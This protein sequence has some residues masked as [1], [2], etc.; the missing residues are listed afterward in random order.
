[1]KSTI[2]VLDQPKSA[3]ARRARFYIVLEANRPTAGSARWSLQ[4]VE[5]V[6]IGR[7]DVRAG[8]RNRVDGA[9]RLTI[10]IP[11]PR[12]S[13]SHARVARVAGQWVLED[14]ESKNGT[15]V[16]GVAVTRAVLRTGDSVEMGGTLWQYAEEL[17]T[18][19]D[20]GDL[21][22]AT[23]DAAPRGFASVVAS[24]E[25]S[26]S[27]LRTVARTSAVPI[28]LTGE[29]GTG[30]ELAARAV[31]ELSERKGRF[32]AVNCGAIPDALVESELFGHRRGAFSGATEDRAGF[33][34]SADG[35]TLLL[36][37]IGDLPSSAQ[38]TLLRVLQEHEVV[39]IGATTPVPVDIRVVAATHQRLDE[40]AETGDF[41][42]DLLARLRG[43][44]IEL[45][46]LRDRR[47]DLGLIV[48]DLLGRLASAH[49][50]DVELALDAA[51]ALVAYDWPLNAR[52][53]EQALSVA[54]GLSDGVCIE[55]GHLPPQVRKALT[56]R[57]REPVLGD[58]DAALRER[59][60][61]LLREHGG[62]V[63]AVARA[64]GKDRKQI[65]R[66]IERFRIR[67]ETAAGAD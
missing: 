32:V 18:D 61:T 54:L 67:L 38:A 17:D 59:L 60:T 6:R 28:L 22:S 21:D 63:S 66:W 40:M 65:R 4:G 42:K 33:V 23:L 44:E 2:S 35:G 7:G 26:L 51:R 20:P 43:F 34:R 16:N 9:R 50:S 25:Q 1:M 39:P 11:D 52:E 37:E 30:K 14:S 31:H 12:L 58:E 19:E 41:R 29:S 47:P 15:R 5:E 49:A 48:S 53:L 24:V 13:A 3:G 56:Q 36:D 57:K 27:Q 62:N 55:L 8:E 46:P 10:T 45:P 64:M